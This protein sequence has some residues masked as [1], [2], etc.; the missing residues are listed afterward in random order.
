MHHL[1]NR[2]MEQYQTLLVHW[3]HDVEGTGQQFV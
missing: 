2:G 1:L 3:L